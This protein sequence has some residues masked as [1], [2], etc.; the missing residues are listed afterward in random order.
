MKLNQQDTPLYARLIQFSEQHPISFHVPGHK[1][2]SIFLDDAKNTFNHILPIDLTELTGLDDLHAPNGV[3]AEAEQLAANFFG[4]NQTFFLVG[5]STVGNLAMILA[6][7]SAG[8]KIIVQRNSHKSIINGLELSGAM[9]VFIAPLYDESVGRFTHPDIDT[10]KQALEIH[11]DVK[12]VV[13]TYPDYFGKTYPLRQMIDLV[14]SYN[15]PILIDEAHGVHFSLGDPFPPSALKLGADIVVQSAHKMAPALTMASYLHMKTERIAADR[16]A[17]YLQ[18]LQSS[19]PSY[20]LMASLDIARSFLASIS[21]TDIEAVKTSVMQVRKSF[22][23]SGFWN[24]L[25]ITEFD[26]PLKLTLSVKPGLTG[27]E[28]AHYFEQGGIYP[29]L[30]THNQVLF[31]H[32]LQPFEKL[33]QLRK[34]MKS[35][36]DQLKIIE[37]H[38]TIEITKMFSKKMGTLSLP[39]QKMN[40]HKTATVS[41]KQAIGKVA[42]EAVIPYPPGIPLVMKGERITGDH[43]KIIEQLIIQGV[44]IQHR[45]ITRGIRVFTGQ[46]KEKN[47]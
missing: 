11:P 24:L 30:A 20:P 3:I 35:V 31:I 21:P 42:A 47:T 25:P 37:S 18:M 26:D 8:E 10:L 41:L 45:D 4:A 33:M 43:I 12:A 38:A 13:L 15:I 17:H 6:A 7:C 28:L 40:Q 16:I 9:P 32:G 39:Y 46:I 34:V 14:H 22:A 1:N 5:G 2:G 36:M 23:L 19:S 29:E 44:T 27:F